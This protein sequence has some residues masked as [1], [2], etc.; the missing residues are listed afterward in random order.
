MAGAVSK[1]IS[2]RPFFADIFYAVKLCPAIEKINWRIPD[3]SNPNFFAK[4]F[5]RMKRNSIGPFGDDFPE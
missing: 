2:I 3:G 4:I 5:I 1:S